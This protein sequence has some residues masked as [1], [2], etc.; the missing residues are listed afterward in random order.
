M[1]SVICYRLYVIWRA[2]GGGSSAEKKPY[3]PGEE[4]LRDHKY[5]RGKYIEHNSRA[6][7]KCTKTLKKRRET[8][9]PKGQRNN[10]K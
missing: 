5:V 7:T 9:H 10:G 2:F 4:I 6:Y 3:F 1:S 8:N